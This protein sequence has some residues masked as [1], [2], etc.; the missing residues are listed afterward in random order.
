MNR[1]Q[2]CYAIVPVKALDAA[3]SRLS[4]LLSKHERKQ[5]SIKML[6]DVLSALAAT[7]GISETVVVSQDPQVS[8]IAE[9]FQMPV[10][11]ESHSGLNQAVSEATDW[12]VGNAA[13][14]VLILQR[15]GGFA[16]ASDFLADVDSRYDAMVTLRRPEEIIR[17]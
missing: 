3:K 11:S 2:P 13:K 14:S 6:E 16:K 10:L 8:Q 9:R 4:P 12:C 5:L 7:R 15:K 17:D 1:I